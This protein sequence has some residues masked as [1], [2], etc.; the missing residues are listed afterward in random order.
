L[1]ASFRRIADSLL[2]ILQ[3][4]LRLFSLELQSERLRLVDLLLKLAVALAFATVGLLLGTYTLA[5]FVW[6]V[7]GYA[8]LVAMTALLLAVGGFLVWRIRRELLQAPP[9]FAKTIAEFKKDR[10]CL[11]K[12]D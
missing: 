3:A 12:N 10:E 7:A 6:E 4:R 8:G 5:R 1:L 11:P 2:G 9:P